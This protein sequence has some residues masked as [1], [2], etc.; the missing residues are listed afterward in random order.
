MVEG[1]RSRRGGG[2]DRR[3]LNRN[4]R[5][6]A[7]AL[8]LLGFGRIAARRIEAQPVADRHRLARGA[9]IIL[10]GEIEAARDR[11][12]PALAIA[13]VVGEIMIADRAVS[14]APAIEGDAAI[15]FGP[16]GDDMPVLQRRP[17]FDQPVAV[18]IACLA[19]GKFAAP[20]LPHERR[21]EVSER[22]LFVRRRRRRRGEQARHHHCH[23]HRPLLPPV[24]HP[25]YRD[26]NVQSSYRTPSIITGKFT[27][28]S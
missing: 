10:V 27:I 3:E 24:L 13:A 18:R 25:V 14:T 6:P 17:A 2:A 8:A 11:D 20:A 12:R 19:A 4:E 16:A 26:L 15:G 21:E 22:G 23:A 5:H 7:L 28:F 1:D 9:N